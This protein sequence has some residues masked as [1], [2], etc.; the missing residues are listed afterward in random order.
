MNR[1]GTNEDLEDL[2]ETPSGSAHLRNIARK[3]RST[4]IPSPNQPVIR[5]Q[6]AAVALS[7]IASQA[8]ER[9]QMSYKASR[10]EAVWL[11]DSLRNFF[12]HQWFSDVLRMIKGG[13]EASVY[14]CE[15]NETTGLDLIAAKVYRPRMFRNLKNDFTYREGRANLD[16]S[17]N[18]VTNKG[19]LHA[20]RKRT[21][22]GRDLL[23]TSWLEHEFKTMQVLFEAGADVP[24]PLAS[25]ANAILM[26]YFGDDVMGAPTL[27][28]VDLSTGEARVLYERVI[29]NI[30][31]MLT[32]GR[33]HADL[34]AF[35]I[36]YWDGEIV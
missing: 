12:I 32:H 16:E 14:L 22:Y 15:G 24:K 1:N 29:H 31:L 17:G 3:K 28:D 35:N 8:D 7:G 33:I 11:E 26:T 27:N 5:R 25:D 19:M 34:S 10:H 20:I 6:E 4:R 30:D 23:H 13:K 9:F 18:N 21:E 2:D 36:L